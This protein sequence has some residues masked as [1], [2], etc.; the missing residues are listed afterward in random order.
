MK[1]ILLLFLFLSALFLLLPSCGNS[2]K[3]LVNSISLGGTGDNYIVT[4]AKIEVTRIKLNSVVKIPIT[5]TN[6]DSQPK[7]FQLK[8]VSPLSGETSAGYT[9]YPVNGID[10]FFNQ[11]TI[12]IEGGKKG[13]VNF[14]IARVDKIP[15]T[16]VWVNVS[17]ETSQQITSAYIVNILIKGDK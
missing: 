16:Q 1:R 6:S 11:D 13:I 5:I 2:V 4:P 10:T 12:T 7:T 9:P 14:F 17:V 8:V 3:I 15:D